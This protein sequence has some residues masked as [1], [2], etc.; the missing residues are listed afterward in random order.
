MLSKKTDVI[1]WM[2]QCLNAKTFGGE[3]YLYYS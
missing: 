3:S 1:V 2:L